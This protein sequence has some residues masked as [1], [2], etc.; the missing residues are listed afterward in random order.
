MIK[1]HK[2]SN[3]RLQQANIYWDKNG[4]PHSSEFGDIYFSNQGGLEETEYV[5][6]QQ[7]QLQQRWAKL[8][9]TLFVIAE[10]GFGT[11][12]NFLSSW[13]LWQKISPPHSRLHYIAC[14]KH[15]LK[16]QDLARALQLWPELEIYATA[17]LEQYPDHSPGIHRLHLTL[18]NGDKTVILDLHYGDAAQSLN[19]LFHPN[20]ARVDAWYLDGFAPKLNPSLW[21]ETLFQRM[22]HLSK[23]GTTVSTY[24]AVGAVRRGLMQQGFKMQKTPGFGNK[25]EM[26]SGV[27]SQIKTA[28]HPLCKNPWFTLPQSP[29]KK[30]GGNNVV[31]I[32]AGLA[33]CSTAYSLALRACNVTLIER[34]TRI[35]SR[36][37]GNKQAVLYCKIAKSPTAYS[38]F[39]LQSYLFAAGQF[40]VLSKHIDIAWH[41]CGAIQLAHKQREREKQ[42][43]I[44]ARGDYSSQIVQAIGAQQATDIAGLQLTLGGFYFPQSG[45]LSPQSLCNAYTQLSRIKIMTRTEALELVHTGEKWQLLA[46]ADADR[47]IIAEAE[48][49]V[50]ATSF[51][52]TQF[53]QLASEAINPLIPVRGQIN[54]LPQNGLSQRLSTVL[55]AEGSVMPAYNGMHSLGASYSTVLTDPTLQA[56][57]SDFNMAII[58]QYLP[59]LYENFQS[60]IKLEVGR[61]SIR[62]STQD[63][64][65][66]VGAVA[67]YRKFRQQ[68]ADLSRNARQQITTPGA[69]HPG[70]Y[71]NVG[72]GSHGLSTCP[73]SAEY[74]A[75]LICREP[76]PIERE[77]IAAIHP[78][79]FIIKALKRQKLTS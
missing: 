44:T 33:G 62:C 1:P 13:R 21:S 38:R 46:A 59:Q 69:Y 65:P 70:L 5:F 64:A 54:Y 6:L 7:N 31:V 66:L 41:P 20:G 53:S 60:T 51:D 17:L 2:K 79:R 50:I 71:I 68:Y 12:L 40:R 3:N 42:Q 73:L 34:E 37:S 8:K 18:T 58:K 48:H 75:S 23:T 22:A 52:A 26:L 4:H 45:W 77:L 39:L 74:L 11:G 16:Y 30:S 36:A 19:T 78:A 9:Q 76:S 29:E 15:P 61:V 43:S 10:T 28:A 72:H 57:E 47:S 25:R 63:Y 55:C 67:D 49:V 27:F 14:E 24:T 56:Q 35:A 32:G